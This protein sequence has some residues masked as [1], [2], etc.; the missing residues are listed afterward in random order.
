MI[1]F[2]TLCCKLS[3]KCDVLSTQVGSGLSQFGSWFVRFHDFHTHLCLRFAFTLYSCFDLILV[4][5]CVYFFE[6]SVFKKWGHFWFDFLLHE[7]H[8]HLSNFCFSF[9]FLPFNLTFFVSFSFKLF[10]RYVFFLFLVRFYEVDQVNIQRK[11]IGWIKGEKFLSF[12]T[13][14]VLD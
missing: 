12:Y 14:K 4:F 6:F 3:V 1:L 13:P 11:L 2:V 10:S 7:R 5:C 8:V 9:L